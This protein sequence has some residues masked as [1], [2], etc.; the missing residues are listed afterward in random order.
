MVVGRVVLCCS[1]L[2][3]MV[4]YYLV[5][6]KLPNWVIKKIEKNQTLLL[7]EDEGHQE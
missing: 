2:T 4:I 6:V 7:D 1:V 5:V 3:S